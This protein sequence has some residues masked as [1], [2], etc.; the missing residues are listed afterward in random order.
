MFSPSIKALTLQVKDP[1]GGSCQLPGIYIRII[2]LEMG[3]Q[4][5]L[6]LIDPLQ[7]KPQLGF[8]ILPSPNLQVL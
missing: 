5:D 6:N 7:T 3:N 1:L 4:V 2:L 8:Q